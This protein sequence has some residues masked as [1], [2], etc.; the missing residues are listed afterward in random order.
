LKTALCTSVASDRQGEKEE[1]RRGERLRSLLFRAWEVGKHP[2]SSM[3]RAWTILKKVRPITTSSAAASIP[4][5]EKERLAV[6]GMR[7]SGGKK[8]GKEAMSAQI[9]QKTEFRLRK[10]KGAELLQAEKSNREEMGGNRAQV[11][12]GMK[13]GR[14]PR[15]SESR[16][17]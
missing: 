16:N 13:R 10:R 12:D 17:V 2:N 5:R 7:N 3:R 4:E 11:L 14:N 1:K 6:P 15:G 8:K 9:D